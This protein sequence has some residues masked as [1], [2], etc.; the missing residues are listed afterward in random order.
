MQQT[1][2]YGRTSQNL[3]TGQIYFKFPGPLLAS[4]YGLK[5]MDIMNRSEFL[6]YSN[7][8]P[9]SIISGVQKLHSVLSCNP[10]KLDMLV[11]DIILG[12]QQ[13]RLLI[14]NHWNTQPILQCMCYS[15]RPK[16]KSG[17]FYIQLVLSW[18]CFKTLKKMPWNSHQHEQ[19][20]TISMVQSQ[21]YCIAA[22][23]CFHEFSFILILIFIGVIVRFND[24]PWST[25][26]L[27]F[28]FV[29]I[30]LVNYVELPLLVLA[31]C[32]IHLIYDRVSGELF[33]SW[34]ARL[35]ELVDIFGVAIVEPHNI[36]CAV[37]EVDFT[38]FA[39]L[40]DEVSI[41]DS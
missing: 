20:R 39:A 7:E 10:F 35:T 29:D 23:P 1:I 24:A 37:S 31:R 5:S 3:R 11:N 38:R 33:L 12:R 28:Q 13:K 14:T 9:P 30:G 18:I 17:I 4:T 26:K 8:I 34:Y 22:T 36:H 27:S 6:R 16:S 41:H 25:F 21:L 40:A 19:S 32:N 15:K 2:D